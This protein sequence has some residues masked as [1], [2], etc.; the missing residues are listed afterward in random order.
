LKEFN[1]I[2]L[3]VAREILDCFLCQITWTCNTVICLIGSNFVQKKSD[4]ISSFRF[5]FL[6]DAKIPTSVDE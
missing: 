1:M 2:L 5:V 3:Y 4:D 6:F